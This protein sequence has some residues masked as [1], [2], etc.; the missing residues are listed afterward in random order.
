MHYPFNC[1]NNTLVKEL[2]SGRHVGGKVEKKTLNNLILRSEVL[3]KAKNE[4][5]SSM[6]KGAKLSIGHVAFL[7][8]IYFFSTAPVLFFFPPTHN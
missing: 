6:T 5:S 4:R 3:F 2:L 7:V 1:Y 8:T